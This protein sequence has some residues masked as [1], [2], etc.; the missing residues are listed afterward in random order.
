MLNPVSRNKTKQKVV[1]VFFK[2]ISSNNKN[3]PNIDV[4]YNR[5]ELQNI[6]SEKEAEFKKTKSTSV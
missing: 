4:C 3:E 5:D 1:Y 6:L 2:N